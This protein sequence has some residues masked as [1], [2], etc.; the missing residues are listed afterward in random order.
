MGLLDRLIRG[1]V[2]LEPPAEA[3]QSVPAMDELDLFAHRQWEVRA[4]DGIF[5]TDLGNLTANQV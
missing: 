3:L 1:L 5:L 2:V 4:Q